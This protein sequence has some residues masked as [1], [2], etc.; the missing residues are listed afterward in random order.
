MADGR[1]ELGGGKTGNRNGYLENLRSTLQGLGKKGKK[2]KDRVGECLFP[3]ATKEAAEMCTVGR[4][5]LS[6]SH[7]AAH[8]R[9]SLRFSCSVFLWSAGWMPSGKRSMLTKDTRQLNV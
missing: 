5:E 2:E 3:M 8:G 6:E 9:P 7:G 1:R 4:N